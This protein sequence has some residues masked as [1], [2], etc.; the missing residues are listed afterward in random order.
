MKKSELI[1]RKSLK[2]CK[3]K[4]I[5]IQS[6]AT[7]NWCHKSKKTLPLTVNAFGAVLYANNIAKIDGYKDLSK[8]LEEDI[9]WLHRFSMG[10]DRGYQITL[11]VKNNHNNEYHPVH[12]EISKLGIDLAKE[13]C[14]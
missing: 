10:F 5:I 6:G 14:K 13:Y 4:E 2:Y 11:F 7:F 12:D 3:N 9:F 8:I 1:I